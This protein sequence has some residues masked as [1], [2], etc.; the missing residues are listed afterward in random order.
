MDGTLTKSDIAGLVCNLIGKNHIHN[1]YMELIEKASAN[2]YKIVWLTMR[3]IN[4]YSFSKAY[5]KFH[6]KISGALFTEPEQF[7]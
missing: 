6:T 2:G 3:S 7:I 5:I 4:L 1:G